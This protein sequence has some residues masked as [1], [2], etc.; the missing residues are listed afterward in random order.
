MCLWGYIPYYGR[1]DAVGRFGS[2]G[3]GLQPF[4]I[5]LV[6]QYSECHDVEF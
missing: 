2:L 1:G 5:F 3:Q 6:D 4:W